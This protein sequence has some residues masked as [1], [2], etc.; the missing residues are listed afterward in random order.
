[1]V[2]HKQFSDWS[3]PANN[4]IKVFVANDNDED[5]RKDRKRSRAA[6]AKSFINLIVSYFSI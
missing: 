5:E 2:A 3:A 4:E 6:Y 1:M